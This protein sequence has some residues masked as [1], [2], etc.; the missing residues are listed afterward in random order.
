MVDGGLSETATL[1][2]S[3]IMGLLIG[4]AVREYQLRRE[5]SIEDQQRT[6]D[7]FEEL[8]TVAGRAEMAGGSTARVEGE[9]RSAAEAL[10]NL[11][12]NP[13]DTVDQELIDSIRQVARYCDKVE[14]AANVNK[15]LQEDTETTESTVEK[16]REEYPREF[17]MVNTQPLDDDEKIQHS[18]FRDEFPAYSEQYNRWLEEMAEMAAQLQDEVSQNRRGP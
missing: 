16:F 4:L 12:S 6:E 11:A 2:L 1:L 14:I 8:E 9:M 10:K 13:P 17:G 7:W 15:R 3:G 5:Q 18:T